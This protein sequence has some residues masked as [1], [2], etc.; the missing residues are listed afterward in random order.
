ML[1][2]VE[3]GDAGAGDAECEAGEESGVVAYAADVEDGLDLGL[4]EREQGLGVEGDGAARFAPLRAGNGSATPGREKA[5]SSSR[6]TIHTRH[7]WAPTSRRQS[8]RRGREQSLRRGW[9]GSATADGQASTRIHTSVTLNKRSRILQALDVGFFA[10]EHPARREGSVSSAFEA[11]RE[12]QHSLLVHPI[13]NLVNLG[14]GSRHLL[15]RQ[16]AVAD[17]RHLRLDAA[18]S[19]KPTESAKLD[20]A[21]PGHAPLHLPAIDRAHHLGSTETFAVDDIEDVERVPRRAL[22]PVLADGA[23]D[24]AMIVQDIVEARLVLGRGLDGVDRVKGR[25]GAQEA[26]LQLEVG[27][28]EAEGV[29][30]RSGCERQ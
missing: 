4:V 10:V 20:V 22:A 12:N 25:A 29:A 26:A 15:Q 1:A 30:L 5:V 2:K 18:A 14:W 27:V 7:R 21:D 9:E 13:G 28:E 11:A 23:R 17:V 3:L 8:T 6:C 16:V 19:E 24:G